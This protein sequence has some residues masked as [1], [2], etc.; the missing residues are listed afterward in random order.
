MEE[1]EEAR[2]AP[3]ATALN[4]SRSTSLATVISSADSGIAPT[5]EEAPRA[6]SVDVS[7]ARL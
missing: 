7:R 6:T 3:G 1:E 5:R 4:Q 2:G